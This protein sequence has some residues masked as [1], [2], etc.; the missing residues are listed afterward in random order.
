VVD[1]QN[2]LLRVRNNYQLNNYQLNN[3]QLDNYQLDNYQLDIYINK[4]DIS[5]INYVYK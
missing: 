4:Y 5:H 3:Y 1:I 2:R